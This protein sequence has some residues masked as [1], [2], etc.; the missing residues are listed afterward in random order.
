MNRSRALNKRLDD[1]FPIPE[2]VEFRCWSCGWSTSFQWDPW[3]A[4]IYDECPECGEHL[5]ENSEKAVYRKEKGLCRVCNEPASERRTRYCSER[6][7]TIASAVQRMFTWSGVRERVLERDDHTCQNPGCGADVSEDGERDPEVDHIQPISED[8][9]PLD[10]RNLIT[11]CGECHAEKT[12][13]DLSV[14]T[15]DAPGL[16]LGEYLNSP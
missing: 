8:G 15:E 3:A 16:S 2:R 6:C 13:G 5:G 9:H 12:H 14:S 7:K 11:L 10:E 1:L 4:L